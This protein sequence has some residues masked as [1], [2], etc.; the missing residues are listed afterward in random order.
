MTRTFIVTA[1]ALAA[2]LVAPAAWAQESPDA[3]ERAVAAKQAQ[4]ST[5]GPP[6]VFERAVAA[7]NTAGR[8]LVFDSYRDDPQRT[9]TPAP[10][11]SDAGRDVEW[12][13]VAA[14]F[15]IGL[16]LALGLVLGSR[17]VRVR[18]LAH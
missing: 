10:V 16:L 6:D 9:T 3:F 2:L 18:P 12:P 8:V 7:R 11:R 4:Q 13:Q 14:G 1:V 15:A 5:Q 17:L